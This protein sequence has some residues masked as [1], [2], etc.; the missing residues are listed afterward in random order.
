MRGFQIASFG[1]PAGFVVFDSFT[2]SGKERV[3]G[4]LFVALVVVLDVSEKIVKR[5]FQA[6]V[7]AAVVAT[8]RP[9][10]MSGVLTLKLRFSLGTR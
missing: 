9:M 4:S 5:A 7:A 2:V 1:V 3:A 6:T 10:I 8:N